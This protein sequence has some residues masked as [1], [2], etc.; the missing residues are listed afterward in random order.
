[1]DR[2]K[3]LKKAIRRLTKRIGEARKASDFNEVE[4][5]RLQRGSF[6]KQLIDEFEQGFRVVNGK[7]EFL[8]LEDA[9]EHFRDPKVRRKVGVANATNDLLQARVQLQKRLQRLDEMDADKVKEEL[10]GQVEREITK[11]ERVIADIN[12]QVGNEPID[13]DEID[14]KRLGDDDYLDGIDMSSLL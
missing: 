13:F 3:E 14:K 1:M 4:N 9:I 11:V 10:L 7:T 5:L 8:P 2:E 6:V 12:E